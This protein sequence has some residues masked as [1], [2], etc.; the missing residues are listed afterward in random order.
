MGDINVLLV[1]STFGRLA[2]GSGQHVYMLW[3]HLKDKVNFEVWNV[4]SVGYIDIPK[5]KS[6]SFLLKAKRKK[7]PK[8]IDIIHIH[9]PKFAALFREGKK[10]VLTMHGDYKVELEVQYGPLAKPIIHY[11]DENLKRANII[12]TVSP[13]WSKLRGWV[14]I[15]NMVELSEIGKISPSGEEYVLFVGRDD[16]VKNYPLFR[17]I[18]EETYKTLGLKSLAL[19]IVRGDTEFLRHAKVPWEVVISY[20]KSAVVLVITSKQEGLPT[21]LLEAW[22]SG[23]PV[24][25]YDIP[26]MRCLN[27]MYGTPLIFNNARELVEM[28][29]KL[30]ET[31]EELVKRGLEAVKNFDVPK[32]V[33]QYYDLYR[34]LI[35][36]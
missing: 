9:N 14:W 7:I 35:E 23:C 30:S 17:N 34:N 27:D 33:E 10:N 20:M 29:S 1:N 6:I 24:L 22:A 8:D 21:V 11:I 31:K 12:T 36:R 13:Y 3:K 2:S 32:V 5:L 16:P 4:E 25:A 26:P 19:G 18:A 15:P 28:I